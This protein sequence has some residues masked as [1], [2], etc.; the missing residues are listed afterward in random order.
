MPRADLSDF[1]P[2]QF[3][4]ADLAGINLSRSWLREADFSRAREEGVQFGEL[5]HLEEYDAV[6]SCCYSPNGMLFAVSRDI[7]EVTLYNSL[8][9][10]IIKGLRGHRGKINDL[11]FSPDSR[12]LASA[13]DDGT[14]RVWGCE[15]GEALL[16][17]EG[18]IGKVSSVTVSP[19]G[20]YLASASVDKTVRM[21]SFETGVM[22]S[23]LKDYGEVVARVEFT[24]GG[25]Q[26]VSGSEVEIIRFCDVQTGEPAGMLWASNYGEVKCFAVSSD[27]LR[28]AFGYRRGAVQLQDITTR[29][30]NLDF[31]A[32]TGDILDIA[33]S[34]N[35]K[36]IAT[37]GSDTTVRVWDATNGALISVLSGHSLDVDVVLFSPD[38]LQV[39]SGSRDGTV[40]LWD[41][42]ST[43]SNAEQQGY[44]GRV[45]AVA[46]SPDGE[47]VITGSEDGS[48][49]RWCSLWGSEDGRVLELPTGKVKLMALSPDRTQ[50]AT[51]NAESMICLRNLQTGAPGPILDGHSD[52]VLAFAYS[53]CGRWIASS[54][55]DNSVRL[56][57]LHNVEQGHVLV[58][59]DTTSPSTLTYSPTDQL[60]AIG[61]ANRNSI[62]LWDLENDESVV[63]L[64]LSDADSEGVKCIAFSPCGNW[65]AS[66]YTG[67]NPVRLWHRRRLQSGN[68]MEKDQVESWRSVPMPK[69]FFDTVTSI[70]W[71]PVKPLEIV[72]S[73]QDRSV[74]V[75]RILDHGDGRHFT[76]R[77]LWGINLGRLHMSGLVIGNVTGLEPVYGRVLVEGGGVAESCSVKEGT[78]V[79]EK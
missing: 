41:L 17:L 3:Q 58:K 11:V 35:S 75:W 47:T 64:G 2:A 23:I 31:Q 4:E 27:G 73:S 24:A 5:P 9:W 7:G 54:G 51:T 16:V 39:S 68:S 79:S 72:T 57:D 33:F 21:W 70:T 14:I 66:G 62:H 10:E 1:D 52:D 29:S 30:P 77:M 18:H 13:G 65:I 40:R 67:D 78:P 55:Q 19:C 60:L 6:R 42:T 45:V 76:V 12:R 34:P 22:L 74:R 49:R 44:S 59:A 37:S 46:Y 48:V 32:H 50:V 71:N 61:T 63:H 20:K 69:G 8:T 43:L 56:W 25:E 26:L 36:W 53:P 15:S 38:G 28:I